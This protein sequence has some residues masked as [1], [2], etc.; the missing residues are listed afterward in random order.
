MGTFCFIS[1]RIK[2]CTVVTCLHPTHF[3]PV[4]MKTIDFQKSGILPHQPI[5]FLP[6]WFPDFT[7]KQVQLLNRTEPLP[8]F[9]CCDKYFVLVP[10]LKLTTALWN[11]D[12]GRDLRSFTL[13]Y[14]QVFFPP[15]KS[16]LV[17][18]LVLFPTT[19]KRTQDSPTPP[20]PCL[21]YPFLAHTG[22]H[23]VKIH[24]INSVS[25]MI[26]VKGPVSA[27]W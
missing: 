9:R 3:T 23:T 18:Y 20:P 26:F 5:P 8:C 4:L 25:V 15:L 24:K 6:K 16:F 11:V 14:Y 22:A 10:P 2:L 1:S 17:W 12:W 7:G 19:R 21:A 27:S 13:L